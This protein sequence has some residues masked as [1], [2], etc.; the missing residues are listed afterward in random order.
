MRLA[1][2]SHISSAE[3]SRAVGAGL[4][5]ALGFLLLGSSM[6]ACSS[7]GGTAAAW[8]GGAGTTG[9][10]VRPLPT[11]ET[12]EDGGSRD[13]A[14]EQSTDG[15]I[16]NCAHGTQLCVDKRW[17]TCK[18]DPTRQTTSVPVPSPRVAGV[19][20]QS[21]AGTS[22]A[23]LD[24]PCDPYCKTYNDVPD[25]PITTVPSVTVLSSTGGLL[26]N[27]NVPPA[28]QSKGSLDS[29]CTTPCNTQYCM[30]ACQFDQHCGT[31]ASGSSGCVAF[32]AQESGS[33][34]GADIT[35][36]TTCIT[37][38]GSRKVTVCNR[39]TATA[40][41]GVQCYVFP[42]GSPQYPESAPSLR[43]ATLVM[44]TA[45]ALKAG[46]CETQEI[47]NSVFPNDGVESM[48]CNPPG[49]GTGGSVVDTA[50]GTD[51]PSVSSSSTW[52]NP[53]LGYAAD[54]AYAVA[55][56][57]STTS[58][59]AFPTVYS[60][61]TNWLNPG[62]AYAEDAIN[63][64]VSLPA[65]GGV[66][67]KL[68]TTNVSNGW[69]TPTNAYLASET[70][71]TLYATAAVT[72]PALGS[73]TTSTAR[74]PTSNTGNTCNN[75]ASCTWQNV[76]NMYA[77]ESP[78]ALNPSYA[79]AT[80]SQSSAQDS[81]AIYYG[82]YNFSDLSSSAVITSL[83]VTV[84]WAGNEKTGIVTVQAYKADGTATTTAITRV[85]AGNANTFNE[86]R[87]TTTAYVAGTLT[88][89]DITGSKFIKLTATHTNNSSSD[90]LSVDY[91]SVAV[92]YQVPGS[93]NSSTLTVGGF[94]LSIP[95]TGT[96]TAVNTE[97]KWK[98][99]AANPYVTLGLQPYSGTTALGT[100]LTTTATS[101]LTADTI[102]T[103]SL[104]SSTVSSLTAASLADGT[105]TV[106]VRETRSGGGT[107]LTNPDISAYVDYVKVSVTYSM[108]NSSALATYGGFGLTVPSGALILGLTTEAKWGVTVANPNVTLGLAPYFGSSAGTELTTTAGASPPTT[109]TWASMTTNVNAAGTALSA[110]D[111]AS[112]N[113]SLVARATRVQ[114][115]TGDVDTTA[116]LDAVRAKVSYITTPTQTVDYSGFGFNLPIARDLTSVTAKVKWRVSTANSNVVL[117][118]QAYKDGGLTPVGTETTTTVGSSPPTSDT[119]V[120][121]NLDISSL[122]TVDLNSPTFLVRVRMTRGNTSATNPDVSAYLD[123]VTLT[124]TYGTPTG[125][126]LVECNP[127]NNWSA[128][129]VNPGDPCQDN[130]IISTPTFTVSRVFQATC[131]DGQGPEWS[132]FSYTST[133]PSDSKI[134]FRFR[135][136]APTNGVCV[137]LAPATKD[138]PAALAVAT[139]TPTDTQ[140]CALDGTTPG[141]PVDL[142]K[143]LGGKM[144]ASPI[145]LQMDAYGVPSTDGLSSPTLKTWAARYDCLDNQ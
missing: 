94:G 20:V 49:T 14:I 76:T 58:A 38:S 86:V 18:V 79:T 41:A 132:Y 21:L 34:T 106:K 74:F 3:V 59:Y 4:R 83:T 124:A 122:T 103:Q 65:S 88:L 46:T 16:I 43:R 25:S 123:Y 19:G 120:S 82:G 64:T 61:V 129:K 42:G 87:T 51:F 100:E 143:G 70:P 98:V 145:C 53:Q 81:N 75:G 6:A 102:Q 69:T 9:D 96:I 141:C 2:P 37:P 73:V 90:T 133:A 47:P 126:N 55:T 7:S 33:C 84:H 62:N 137:Q 117:G 104:S 56:S 54:S 110:A 52:L 63:A 17:G 113:F 22:A 28:F 118:F 112:G 13:C 8:S 26:A 138:P 1:R 130:S 10:N 72:S 57:T 95:A 136:F 91:I 66:T 99:S 144:G 115:S 135:A 24:N 12:C 30:E 127:Y 109:L 40:G 39:G 48:M 119:V 107:T 128:T 105:F 111:L 36:P 27:S 67:G 80:L 139:S 60:N 50:G 71:T 116:L 85:G 89:A 31:Q 125:G 134:S 97:V 101:A 15:N 23:C 77:Q 131:P 92:G 11:G 93:D 32:G 121:A 35:A 140:V 44:T 68:P 5:R 108:P 29:R 142:Y 45:S 78:P 114:G